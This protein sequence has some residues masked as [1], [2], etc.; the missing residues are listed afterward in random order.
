MA[1]SARERGR[2]LHVHLAWGLALLGALALGCGAKPPPGDDGGQPADGGGGGPVTVSLSHAAGRV[3]AGEALQLVA[4]VSGA[5]DP[6]V[7]WAVNDVTGGDAALGTIDATGRY[8]APAAVPSP[9]AVTVR[10]TS[11]AVPSA[12]ATATV[13]VVHAAEG[14]LL[15]RYTPGPVRVEGPIAHG[16]SDACGANLEYQGACAAAAAVPVD[17]GDGTG[18]TVAWSGQLL[19]PVSGAWL[20]TSA[21]PVDGEVFVSVAG[22]TVVDAD[23]DGEPWAGT[24]TLVAGEP[25]PVSLRFAP[26]GGHHAMRLGWAAPGGAAALVPKAYLR[27]AVAVVV[28]G[29]STTV[30]AGGSLALGVEVVGSA[31]GAVDWSLTPGTC[32]AEAGSVSTDGV[33]TAGSPT[34]DCEVTVV[35][36]SRADGSAAGSLT[37]TLEAP[38]AVTPS[39]LDTGTGLL[40]LRVAGD[41]AGNA[42]A[43]WR[44]PGALPHRADLWAARYDAATR[45]WSAPMHVEDLEA[46]ATSVAVDSNAAGDVVVLYFQSGVYARTYSLGSGTWTAPPVALTA[47]YSSLGTP[48]VRVDPAGNAWATWLDEKY[49]RRHL[50]SRRYAVATHSWGAVQVI[51]DSD[52][53]NASES[54]DFGWADFE[55][56]TVDAHG[57]AYLVWR[58]ERASGVF[59]AMSRGVLATGQWDVPLERPLAGLFGQE[60]TVSSAAD[61]AMALWWSW[62]GAPSTSL[63]VM[64]SRFQPADGTWSAPAP[65]YET[66]WRQAAV[67]LRAVGDGLGNLLAVLLAPPQP[68]A[69]RDGWG[70]FVPAGATAG[71]AV[72][73]ENEPSEFNPPAIALNSAGRGLIAWTQQVAGSAYSELSYATFDRASGVFSPPRRP[74]PVPGKHALDPRVALA[75]NGQALVLWLQDDQVLA[76]TLPGGS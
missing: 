28:T 46:S 15:A 61:A 43:V 51:D 60:A 26:N 38:V 64:A 31:D 49:S 17:W 8:V 45:T 74:W 11:L 23:L 44:K 6:G 59:L 25:V 22:V 14:G 7:T 18:F 48:L 21:G 76:L 19:A 62:P 3:L 30:A 42:L 47:T 36:T 65:L 29:S 4:T 32:G 52:F 54:A 5:A 9:A 35:A 50:F 20:L 70:V 10:A 66:T 63:F 68:G 2:L 73:L 71:P 39:V 37:L 57:D 24:V 53:E 56:L 27:P 34:A 58:Q 16:W 40:D 41:A 12:S 67:N 13:T 1:V 69:H 55:G 75:A 33:Y 72:A